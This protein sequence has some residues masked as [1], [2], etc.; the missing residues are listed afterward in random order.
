MSS[1]GTWSNTPLAYSYQWE[2]C[3]SSGGECAVI[4]GAVN[5]GYY[6]ALSDEKRKLVALVTAVNAGGSTTIATPTTGLVGAGTPI[7]GA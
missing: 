1:N 7:S 6:P 4:P 3:N 2:D 5:E